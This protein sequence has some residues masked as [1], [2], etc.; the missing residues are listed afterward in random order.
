MS[1]AN[2]TNS[3]LKFFLKYWIFSL[4]KL[5]IFSGEISWN[6]TRWDWA[7]KWLSLISITSEQVSKICSIVKSSSHP[8]H[9]DGSS[10]FNKKEW[11]IKEWPMCNQAITVSSFLFVRG[12]TTH[13]F[14]TGNILCSLF[15]GNSS[16][17]DCHNS[18]I[19]LLAPDF[20]SEKGMSSTEVSPTRASLAAVRL[21]PN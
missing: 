10:P 5:K 11:V 8:V 6:N 20:K 14:K 7:L 4:K 15:P 16:H 2:I 1:K 19:Y 12:Q 9:I 21:Q 3:Y 18:N 17:S 13:S